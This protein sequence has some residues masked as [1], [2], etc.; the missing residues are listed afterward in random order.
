MIKF[1]EIRRAEKLN[2]T[3]MARLCGLPISSYKKYEA[4]IYLPGMEAIEKIAE[5]FPHYA[6]WLITGRVDL[7]NH[8]SPEIVMQQRIA[9]GEPINQAKTTQKIEMIRIAEKLSEQQ[10]CVT[11]DIDL[12]KYQEYLK[13]LSKPTP[14]KIK[15]IAALFALVTYRPNQPSHPYLS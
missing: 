15:Q 6:L 4:S 11:C 3:D 13:G 9:S 8:V 2:Q 5:A 12:D 14:T 7:P 1:K 10:M